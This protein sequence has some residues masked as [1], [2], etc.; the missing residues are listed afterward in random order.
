MRPPQRVAS[1]SDYV[2]VGKVLFLLL[3]SRS[4]LIG[5]SP[6]EDDNTL[7]SMLADYVRYSPPLES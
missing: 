1:T 5:H 7:I 2:S 4:R 6:C 3:T